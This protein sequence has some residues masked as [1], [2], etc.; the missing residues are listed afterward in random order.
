MDKDEA[1]EV[2]RRHLESYRRQSYTRLAALI[3]KPQTCELTAPSGTSYQIEVEASWDDNPNG[4]IHVIG[5]VD[6]GGWRAFVP[7]SEDFIMAP[8]GSLVGKSLSSR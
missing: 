2:L 4:D 1:R 3:G 7:L 6:D 8:D 5:S